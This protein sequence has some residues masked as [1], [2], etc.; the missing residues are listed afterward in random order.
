MH[1]PHGRATA[2]RKAALAWPGVANGPYQELFRPVRL[3]CHPP[4]IVQ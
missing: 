2:W 3:G 4:A 1:A